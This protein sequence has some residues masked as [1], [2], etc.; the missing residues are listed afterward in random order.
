MCEWK[1][2]LYRLSFSS[3]GTGAAGFSCVCC[4]P[5]DDM[6]CGDL[7]FNLVYCDRVRNTSRHAQRRVGRASLCGRISE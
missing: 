3:A 7:N 1:R 2:P 4:E 6:S 5:D